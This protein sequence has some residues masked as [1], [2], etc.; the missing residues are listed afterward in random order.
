MHPGS[1]RHIRIAW[2]D[3]SVRLLVLVVIYRR[4][5][6]ASKTLLSL[7]ASREALEDSLVVVWDNSPEPA[8]AEDLQWLRRWLPRLAYFHD[9]ANPGLASV[10]N[11]VIHRYLK[12]KTPETFDYLVLFDDDSR[13]DRHYFAEL[14]RA[15]NEHAWISLFLPLL[16]A[17]GKIVSPSDLYGFKGFLWKKNRSGIVRARH[18]TAMNSGMAISASYLREEF[19]G[20]DE[21]LRFYGTDNFFMRE[22]GKTHRQFVVLNCVVQHDLSFFARETIETKLWRHRES[23]AALCLLN[24]GRGIETWLTQAYCG[25]CDLRQAIKYRDLR[26]LA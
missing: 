1:K 16:T 2:R 11:R 25:I 7:A 22:Y 10:Y 4:R 9:A 8:L 5:C 19:L 14:K 18:R 6:S 23:V 26:F 13:L 17:Q 20:Y 21:R 24:K 12:T 15:T 3:G